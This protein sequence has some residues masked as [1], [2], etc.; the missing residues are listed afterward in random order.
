VK[1]LIRW[2]P[3]IFHRLKSAVTHFQEDDGLQLAAAISYYA[4]LS[5]F[6][7]LLI[8]ISG[9]GFLLRFTGWGQNTQQQVL[10]FVSEQASPQLASRVGDALQ[11]VQ[12]SAAL[13][14]P[15][16]LV[17]LLIAALLIFAQFESAFD[18]IWNIDQ[19][20]NP[21]VWDTVKQILWHRTRA[22]LMLLSVGGLIVVAFAAGMILSSALELGDDLIALPTWLGT[23]LQLC[24]SVVFNWAMFTLIYRFLPKKP[25]RWSEAAQGGL[26]VSIIWEIGR[27]LLAALVIGNKYSAYGVIGSFIAIM[28]WI[29]YGTI[30]LFFGAEFVQETCNQNES[31]GA[32]E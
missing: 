23:T 4:A 32:A 3:R 1:S 19:Q 30:V 6:P 28:L 24:I 14:G 27:Q 16:G 31:A 29:Y 12:A 8:L 11:E 7:L 22:F 21:S 18:R 17:S 25:V 15:I 26:L 10:K 5:F 13:N 9:L 2:L 20:K